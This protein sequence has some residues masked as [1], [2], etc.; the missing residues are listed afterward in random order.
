MSP[1]NRNRT[2]EE[3]NEKHRRPLSGP[4]RWPRAWTVIGMTQGRFPWG[5]AWCLNESSNRFLSWAQGNDPRGL[6]LGARKTPAL[7]SQ[8]SGPRLLSSLT[9]TVIRIC[10]LY[11]GM[12]DHPGC[13]GSDPSFVL[14]GDPW[15]CWKW[16][17]LDS[18]Q[19]NHLTDLTVSWPQELALR[20]Q[21]C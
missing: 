16:T 8:T 17:L 2:S 21:R 1:Q 13:L 19:G 14:R 11:W 9:R 5:R 18:A 3:L 6:L 12:K 10:L 15:Q 20:P 7:S 4:V